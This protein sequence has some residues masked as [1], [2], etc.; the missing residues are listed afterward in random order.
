MGSQQSHTHA[1][2]DEEEDANPQF[3]KKPI[4]NIQTNL[5]FTGQGTG[6]GPST[7]P[8]PSTSQGTGQGPSSRARTNTCTNYMTNFSINPTKTS[9]TNY[10]TQDSVVNSVIEQFAKRS[11]VGV[12]KYGTTLDR[13]DLTMLDWIQHAQEELMDGILYLEKIKKTMLET[14]KIHASQTMVR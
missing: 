7:G 12:E 2:N 6:Q 9:T 8:G 10:P 1:N 5:P 11:N 3:I 4:E 14:Q 13:T